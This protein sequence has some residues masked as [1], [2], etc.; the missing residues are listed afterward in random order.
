V[1]EYV[2]KKIKMK[3]IVMEKQ[4]KIVKKLVM[5]KKTVTRSSP[6]FKNEQHIVKK[7]EQ[8]PQTRQVKR[9]KMIKRMVKK[10]V[11]KYKNKTILTSRII[12]AKEECGCL[13]TDCDCIGDLGCGCC[14]PACECAPRPDEIERV[15]E[16]IKV[17][18]IDYVTVE[19]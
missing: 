4:E 19:V 1:I 15:N 16:V 9:I 5:R 11:L 8:R 13:T 12:P 3:K 18:F 2:T 14:Y 7:T 10:P 6:S 17:P